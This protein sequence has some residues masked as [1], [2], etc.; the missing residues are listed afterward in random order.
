MFAGG[1]AAA[2]VLS[3][4]AVE[5]RV[6][7]SGAAQAAAQSGSSRT[8]AVPGFDAGNIISD[9][10]FYNSST[11]TES[12][13]ASFLQQRGSG[14]SSTSSATCLKDYR[15][16]T[17]S[18]PGD[19]FC[20]GYQ[21]S[22]NESAARMIWLSAQAC[23]INP[24]VL[25]VTLQKE[26]SLVTS[27]MSSETYKRAMG[28]GCPD[29]A[30]G[31]CDP[32]YSGFHVQVYY[33]ARQFVRYGELKNTFNYFPVGRTS[34]VL[35]FPRNSDGSAPCGSGPVFIRNQA[36]ANLYYYTPYQPNAA[37]L[38]AGTGTGDSC[39]AY[40][41][42]NFY[43]FFTQWFGSTQ[44]AVTSMVSVGQDIYFLT[45]GLR[46]H[47]TMASFEQYRRA[48]GDPVPVS[49][50]YLN[51]HGDGGTANLFVRNASTGHTS[52]LQDGRRFHFDSC[53]RI[54]LWGGSCSALTQLDPAQYDALPAGPQ[55]G[56]FVRNGSSP[57]VHL[58]EGRSMTP[59]YNYAALV[60]I[61]NGRSTDSLAMT[62][63]AF[64]IFTV[65]RTYF[66]PG[67]FVRPVD[68]SS[69]YLPTTDGR[70]VYLPSY[71]WADGMGLSG[72]TDT[73]VPAA[74]LR[75]YVRAGELGLAIRCGNS[76]FIGAQ[77]RL[78]PVTTEAVAGLPVQTLDDRTCAIL[79]KA[80]GTA[81]N[82]VF[83]R[84]ADRSEIYLLADGALRH[85]PTAGALRALNGGTEPSVQL[86]AVGAVDLLPK[87]N[88]V[89][90]DE[91]NP[92]VAQVGDDLFLLTNGSRI[93]LT[94]E[95][96]RQYTDVFGPAVTVS[97]A[98]LER[99]TAAADATFY[100]RSARSG[101]IALLQEGRRARFDS[102]ARL[103]A[104]G[105]DCSTTT[106][107]AS[108]EFDRILTAP[109]V[110]DYVR[111]ADSS[112][113]YRIEGGR[114]VPLYDRAALLASNGGLWPD[115]AAMPPAAF[116]RYA[117]APVRFAPG[118][119]LM[120][121]GSD[122]VSLPTAD[123]RLLHLPSFD[124]ATAWGIP[125]SIGTR[126]PANEVAG[127]SSAPSMT[128]FVRCGN[129]LH[130][131]AGGALE[132]VTSAAAA[133][134]AETAL[135]AWNCGA[136]RLGTGAAKER[137]FLQGAGDD[138]IWLAEAGRLRHVTSY[139]ALVRLGGGT[140][141]SAAIVPG[142]IIDG[143]PKGITLQ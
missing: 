27:R 58:L 72:P 136:L 2:P 13:I 10:V 57:V 77:G 135:D 29:N 31:Q 35:Y 17:Y 119:L 81:L 74:S 42:R 121:T 73:E 115:S 49:R 28:Y 23:G 83:L 51:L 43:N 78:V 90:G 117:K 109:A 79:P 26:Q 70:L 33:S 56:E 122:R 9:T 130:L 98:Y 80:G 96:Y 36:T 20:S 24:Q 50:Q 114:L 128:L 67:R 82:K 38:A 105:G 139:A 99:F 11:M 41:N 86:L 101:E 134:F 102:C 30:G 133:G 129:V 66:A 106:L 131:A 87:G 15:E 100:V 143:L 125:T 18:F 53:D 69:V 107:L 61:A 39:S 110:G 108:A 75:G 55:V 1:L 84:G 124:M 19:Q 95:N 89:S 97:R 5:H 14:C 123:G 54:A 120:T 22:G 46:L 88:P 60:S 62:T 16:T 3:A 132:P 32:R 113:M 21:S 44:S 76:T 126:V 6:V 118:R 112:R 138:R 93:R 45:G 103:T 37:A 40:G 111:T 63:E 85:V 140:A 48:F 142:G 52:L 64:S 137:V 8:A 68:D 12:Q 65:A 25:L 104:W 141:P 59:V 127:Y 71:A 91:T 7:D 47:L 116:L 94:L 4:S 34:D 92:T